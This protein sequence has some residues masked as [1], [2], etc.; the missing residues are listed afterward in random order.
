MAGVA[1]ILLM[2]PVSIMVAGYMKRT[3][4]RLMKI[5]DERLKVMC[6]SMCFVMFVV[7]CVCA[8]MCM[9]S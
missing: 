2:V 4:M 9:Y 1:V 5:K 7:A 8:R 3:Q 6:I